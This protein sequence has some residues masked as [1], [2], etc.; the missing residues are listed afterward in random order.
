MYHQ[1]THIATH[2]RSYQIGEKVEDKVHIDELIQSRRH[3]KNATRRQRLWHLFPRLDTFLSRLNSSDKNYLRALE[4]LLLDYRSDLI[5][6]VMDDELEKSGELDFEVFTHALAHARLNENHHDLRRWAT[7]TI[8]QHPL[9]S[10]ERN[11]HE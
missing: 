4:K 11:S 1:G 9:T 2:L 5:R 3:S 7:R 6:H 8:E 10:F